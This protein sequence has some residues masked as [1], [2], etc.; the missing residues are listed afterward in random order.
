MNQFRRARSLRRGFTL[1]ELLVVI[2]IIAVLIALLLPAVQQ[3]REAARRTQCKNHLKQLGLALHNYESSHSTFPPTGCVAG[4]T[5]TQPWSAQAFMLP[6]LDGTSIY[7]VIDFSLGYQHPINR[8]L[9]P[10]NGV[11]PIRIPVLMCPSEPNDRAR[12]N[13]SGVAE[14]Y[15][16]N[17]AANMGLYHI[18]SPTTGNDGGG[19][20]GP[21]RRMRPGDFIDGMSNT[22]GLAEVKAFT[23]RFHD[24]PGMPTTPPASPAD[25][26]AGYTTGGAWS[27]TSGHTEWVCG[28]AIH[29][30]FTTTFVPRTKVPHTQAG[31]TYDIDVSGLREGVSATDQTH[32]IITSRSHHVGI[33]NALLMD[34]SVRSISENI[35]INVWRALGTRS[36]GEVVG[37]F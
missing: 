25:V 31:V 22:L 33:V 20:L 30:G 2:A 27:V 35:D 14:H 17:Y 8:A 15:P 1:I 21:N 28:R 37:E 36:G 3:A 13:G 34:G 32:A 23:P 7:N 29:T 5:V 26:S 9:F 4:T 12:L 6:Y 16:I 24:V 19:A 11:A 10:P 18:F